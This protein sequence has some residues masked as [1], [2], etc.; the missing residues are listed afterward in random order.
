MMMIER[1][2]LALIEE[3]KLQADQNPGG[4]VD[5]AD[6]SDAFLDGNFNIGRLATAAIKAMRIPTPPMLRAN[7]DSGG[8]KSA[9]F[10]KDDWQVM[11]DAALS[12]GDNNAD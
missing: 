11:I 1:V 6:S 2:T 3:L 5:A 8:V 4:Y 10:V 7:L 12:D 9:S